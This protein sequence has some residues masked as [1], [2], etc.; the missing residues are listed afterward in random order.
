MSPRPLT[1]TTR[2]LPQPLA[3]RRRATAPTNHRPHGCQVGVSVGSRGGRS[4][5]RRT[6]EISGVHWQLLLVAGP[7][8]VRRIATLATV[9][10]IFTT[11]VRDDVRGLLRR[12][13]TQSACVIDHRRGVWS[14]RRTGGRSVDAEDPLPGQA[15]RRAGQGQGDGEDLAGVA[16]GRLSRLGQWIGGCA[17]GCQSHWLGRTMPSR[18]IP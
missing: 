4:V 7:R 5:A 2:P 3:C 13:A 12:R 9:S 18:P 15:G 11:S 10:R 8:V 6:L 1:P 16:A 14:A 17:F